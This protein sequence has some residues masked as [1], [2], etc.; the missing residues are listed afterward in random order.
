MRV[1]TTSST[2][3][4]CSLAAALT[5]LAGLAPEARALQYRVTDIGTLGGSHSMAAAINNRGQVVGTSAL[6]GVND[7]DV[8]CRNVHTRLNAN[9]NGCPMP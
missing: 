7:G 9:V 5:L 8:A 3:T 6:A 1:P 2:R 4:F